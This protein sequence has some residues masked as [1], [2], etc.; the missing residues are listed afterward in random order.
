MDRMRVTLVNR[1][2]GIQQGGG[3]V[4]D[5]SLA[6][7]L[8]RAGTAVEFIS[9]RPLLRSSLPFPEGLPVRLVRTPYLRGLAHRMGG[10]GWRL[11]DLDLRLF[12]AGAERILSREDPPPDVVQ[13]TGLP[14][15]ARRLEAKHGLRVA[16]LFPGPPSTR[17]RE[18]IEACGRV[19]GVGAVTPYLRE[20]FSRPIHHMIGGVDSSL[21]KPGASPAREELGIP[22]DAPVIL[23]AGRL[24]PL[25]NIPLLIEVFSGIRARLGDARLLVVGDGPLRSDLISRATAAGLKAGGPGRDT[26]VVLVGEVPHHEMPSWYAS[27]QLLLLASENESFSLVTLEAMACGVPVVAPRVG[28]LP[29]LVGEGACGRLYPAGDAAAGAE[30]A[31]SLLGDPDRRREA[32]EAARQRALERHSWEAVAAEFNDLYREMVGR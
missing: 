5:L 16:L 24:V 11:L 8:R 9:G 6:A 13:I 7:A 25:K 4:Y 19:I 12:E 22:A 20:N 17:N 10:P 18:A 15:L 26:D 14:R 3:E 1:L 31:L 23:F 32:S 2:A 28:Y 21:F 29:T 27:A 30:G